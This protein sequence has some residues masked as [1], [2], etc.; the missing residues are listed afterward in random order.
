M[1]PDFFGP[2][3]SYGLLMAT[4]FALGFWLSCR[5]ARP[6]GIAKDTVLDL[7]FWVMLSSIIGVRLFFVMTHPEELTPWYNVFNIRSGLTLYGGIIL[8]IVAVWVQT[9]RRG[10]HFL[11]IAD[12]FAPGV[13][14]G[15]GIT[16][17]GCFMAGCCFGQPTDCACGVT[18]PLDAPATLRFGPVPV[19]P[20]QLYAS[21]AGFLSFGVLLFWEKLSA[22]RG[23]TFSR[24]LILYGLA[25]FLLDFFRYY[26]P[27]QVMYLGWSNNQWIS[28]GMMLTGLV[29]LAVTRARHGQERP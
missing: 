11:T 24:F 26:E 7:V 21:G 16:R 19:H 29:L 17:I 22:W 1:H 6:Y 12:I 14:L 25:R 5:R 23:A 18:F 3:K 15:I 28:L 9:R 2:I 8:A 4:S 27:G 13:I 10:I 20:A